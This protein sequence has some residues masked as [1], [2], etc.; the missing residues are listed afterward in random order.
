MSD[1]FNQ[2]QT[3]GV[4]DSRLDLSKEQQYA[5][6]SSGPVILHKYFNYT[7]I[8]SSSLSFNNI[9]PGADVVLSKIFK[10]TLQYLVTFTGVAPAGSTLM[11]SWGQ[12]IAPRCMPVN[13]S[14]SNLSFKI[15]GSNFSCELNSVLPALTRINFR[16]TAEK[17][18]D[19]LTTPDVCQ[20][21]SELCNGT[22]NSNRNPLGAYG[23]GAPGT[24]QCGRGGN[25]G[26]CKLLTDTNTSATMLI[27]VTEPMMLSPLEF[28]GDEGS[29]GFFYLR[30][31][32]ILG[33]FDSDLA[34]RVISVS[35]NCVSFF[36][37]I[38]VQPVN[39][40]IQFTQITKPPSMYLQ[41]KISYPYYNI[42]KYVT[43]IQV[44][45]N[46]GSTSTVVCNSLQI[47]SNPKKIIIFVARTR[48]YAN[49]RTT[50]T[51]ARINNI[52]IEYQSRSGQ[53]SSASV[54]QLFDMSKR[55]GLDM[56]FS[57]FYGGAL[58]SDDLF[59]NKTKYPRMVSGTG[60][61][62]VIDPV[63][64]MGLQDQVSG[65]RVNGYPLQISVNFTSLTPSTASIDYYS[66]T[67]LLINDGLMTLTDTFQCIQQDSV[68]SQADI[69]A[70]NIEPQFTNSDV[71]VA[72]NNLTGG[73]FFGD[74]KKFITKNLPVA[75]DIYKAV[76]PIVGP[77]IGLGCG[78]IGGAHPRFMSTCPHCVETKRMQGMGIVGG[79]LVGGRA[80]S[81]KSLK[82][83][84][85]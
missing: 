7:S 67:I 19:S 85:Y 56:S 33:T 59:N 80:V 55:N 36:S 35:D 52:S 10:L 70:P 29:A 40:T 25:L 71:L 31:L 14:F 50:D 37:N 17:L 47:S 68:V 76:A 53:L 21:Y 16:K 22:N 44:P 81:R 57:E 30:D 5:V 18:S 79:G 41:P 38:N 15:N 27:T 82:N 42:N 49:T 20:L 13:N 75:K 12:D 45:V 23:T 6:V 84:M 3:V 28:G 62:V 24:W 11:A 78:A 2:M 65:S 64:D 54:Q 48:N 39:A 60:S 66:V 83:L 61:V 1:S 26:S 46:G 72:Q 9:N 69:S 43:D 4:R 34:S 63:L 77:L 73:N 74:V 58:S 8:S 51:F 32:S